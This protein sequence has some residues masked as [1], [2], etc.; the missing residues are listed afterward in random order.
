MKFYIVLLILL[1]GYIGLSQNLVPNPSFEEKHM[2]PFNSVQWRDFGSM[3]KDWYSPNFQT[4]DYFHPCSSNPSSSA[5]FNTRFFPCTNHLIAKDGEAYVGIALGKKQGNT[6]NILEYIQVQLL[7]PLHKNKKYVV[8]FNIALN[9]CSGFSY[10]H[11]GAYVSKQLDTNYI[12]YPDTQCCRFIPQIEPQI[13]SPETIINTNGWK[14]IKGVFS[15]SGGE[16]WLT[17]GMFS[18]SQLPTPLDTIVNKH[19]PYAFI[20]AVSIKEIEP[21]LCTDTI[22]C[23]GDSILLHTLY[24][25]C[26]WSSSSEKIDTLSLNDSI[27]LK[28]DSLTIIYLHTLDSSYNIRIYP[29]EKPIVSMPSD[30]IKCIGETIFIS[31]SVDSTDNNYIWSTG[32]Q[33]NQIAINDTGMYFVTIT[34]HGCVIKKSINIRLYQPPL[35]DLGRDTSICFEDRSYTLSAPLLKSFLWYPNKETTQVITAYSPNLYTVEVTDYN[36]CKYADSVTLF[37]GCIFPA[38]IPNAFSPGHKDNIN[39]FFK[40]LI[41]NV[42]FYSMSVY[43]RWGELLF[44]SNQ[45]DLGWDGTFKNIDCP[46]GVYF[47]LLRYSQV[48]VLGERF[49]AQS[50]SFTLIR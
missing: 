1:N 32:N 27:W 10:S 25:N 2:C 5:P 29:V 9:D 20:D 4:P 23:S 46:E 12:S 21:I 37:D 31:A 47:F 15:S 33:T 45:Y 24:S 44:E 42:N 41:N 18:D 19:I 13:Y 3:V 22:I 43:N 48:Y 49:L 35:F 40:P 30:T 26:V 17:I 34:N 50:G 7:K 16:R 39:Q 14:E 36:D 6:P 8:S 38:Y 28:I 11:F